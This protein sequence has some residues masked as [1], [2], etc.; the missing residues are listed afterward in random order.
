MMLMEA[1]KQ[2]SKND[3]E[4][5]H[6]LLDVA[7]QQAKQGLADTRHSLRTLRNVEIERITGIKAIYRL[8]KDFELATGVTIR[9]EFGNLTNHIDSKTDTIVYHVVQE[10]ITNA[11]KHGKASI[12][13]VQFQ[14][15]SNM[16]IITIQDNGEGSG[17]IK[18]GIGLA[19]IRERLEL[20]GGSVKAFTNQEG[21]CLIARI[22][23]KKGEPDASNQNTFS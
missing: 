9:V 16:I 18:E 19:G 7:K 15:L 6:E 12:I 5:L 8:V 3:T 11:F 17:E 21:F 14:T 13:T 23:I 10:G 1:A 4:E 2:L 20:T 22:P